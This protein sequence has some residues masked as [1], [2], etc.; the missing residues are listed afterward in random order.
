MP[1][2]EVDNQMLRTAHNNIVRRMTQAVSS[3]ANV[4][5]STQAYTEACLT[6]KVFDWS[7]HKV[8]YEKEFAMRV[9]RRTS[10]VEGSMVFYSWNGMSAIVEKL[11]GM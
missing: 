8:S 1:T 9:L 10:P 11:F 6:A 2:L 3:Y 4:K 5:A 7:T